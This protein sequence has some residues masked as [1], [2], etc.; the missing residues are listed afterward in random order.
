MQKYMLE[1]TC[2]LK[3]QL[4]NHCNVTPIYPEPVTLCYR[5]SL[6]FIV[7][8]T[9]IVAKVRRNV[10]NR[11]QSRESI[12]KSTRV[13][14]RHVATNVHPHLSTYS[15]PIHSHV[16]NNSQSIQACSTYHGT[17]RCMYVCTCVS[18]STHVLIRL[19]SGVRVSHG[20]RYMNGLTDTRGRKYACVCVRVHRQMSTTLPF[21]PK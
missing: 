21:I 16:N 7:A 14:S 6:F 11:M 12:D 17:S 2:N 4:T 8:V 3:T 15:P 18:S 19:Y 13:T 1:T 20:K 10:K 5:L 9:E